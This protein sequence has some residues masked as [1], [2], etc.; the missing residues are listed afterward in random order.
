MMQLEERGKWI[1]RIRADLPVIH[2]EAGNGAVWRTQWSCYRFIEDQVGP[3]SRTLETGVGVSTVLFAAWGCNH[4]AVVPFGDEVAVESYCDDNGIDR[5]SLRFDRRPS[6]EALPTITGEFDLFLVDGGHGFPLP[7]ID[8]FYGAALLRRGGVVVFDDVHLPQVRLLIDNF[9]EPDPRWER[10]AG[11]AKWAAFRRLS[12]GS[13][14]ESEGDQS[15]FPAPPLSLRGQVKAAMPMWL[16][17]RLR[18]LWK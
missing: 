4:L 11:N 7:I 6:E 3:G 17:R 8:W 10:L 13:L 2:P 12:E 5:G 15:F 14:S 9:I 1:D 16:K 18:T